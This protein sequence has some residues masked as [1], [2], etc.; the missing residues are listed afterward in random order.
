MKVRH[1]MVETFEGD[2]IW[3]ID[4]CVE[5]GFWMEDKGSD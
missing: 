1:E 5:Y 3:H 4:I 2:S